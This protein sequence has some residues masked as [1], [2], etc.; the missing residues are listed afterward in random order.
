MMKCVQ[1]A[2]NKLLV[3]E[4]E[5]FIIFATKWRDEDEESG[6]AYWCSYKHRE[7][8]PNGFLDFCLAVI[9]REFTIKKKAK[10]KAW[11]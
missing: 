8:L 5:L 10:K 3:N 4:K 1:D 6:R 2:A 11:A 9:L 7:E